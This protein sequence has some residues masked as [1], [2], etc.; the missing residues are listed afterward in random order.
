MSDFVVRI[1]NTKLSAKQAAQIASAI[2]GTVLSEL[3]RLDLAPAD[4]AKAVPTGA[5]ILHPE[6]RGIWI[7]NLKDL[8]SHTAP[9]ILQVT[10]RGV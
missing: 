4:A 1:D 10:E 9:P 3:G 6:W 2:Q 7:R 8:Q 5:L